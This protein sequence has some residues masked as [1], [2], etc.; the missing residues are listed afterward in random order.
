[1]STS[2]KGKKAGLAA[3]QT[4][5]P[6]GEIRDSTLV[7]K[8]GGLRAVIQV[9]SVN[10][11]LKS[12]NEQNSLIYAFQSFLNTMEFPIQIVAR[13]KKLDVDA[14]TESFFTIAKKHTNPLMQKITNEYAQYVKKLVEYADIMEKQFYCVVPYDP[15]RARDKGMFSIFFDALNPQDQVSSIK[16]RHLEFDSL[17]KGLSQRL[18]IVQNGLEGMGLNAKQLNTSELVELYYQS[19]NPITSRNQKSIDLEKENLVNI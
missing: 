7:L 9:S 19:F 12:E 5:L 10:F 3:T 6:I 14:Y 4:F 18:D 2:V 15:I 16:K 11:N 13:S 17:K 1:M 8:N